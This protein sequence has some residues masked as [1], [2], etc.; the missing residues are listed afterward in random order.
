MV[1]VSFCDVLIIHLLFLVKEVYFFYI[2]LLDTAIG[3]ITYTKHE[4]AALYSQNIVLNSVL[5][6]NGEM[7]KN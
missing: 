7:L 1:L 3:H 4:V 5:V 2:I 6:K